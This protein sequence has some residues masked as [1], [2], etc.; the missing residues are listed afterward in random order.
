MAIQAEEKKMNPDG[1]Q[2]WN[3]KEIFDSFIIIIYE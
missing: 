2:L 1:N 3:N